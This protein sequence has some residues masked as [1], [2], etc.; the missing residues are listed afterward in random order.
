M[1]EGAQ[2]PRNT[3]RQLDGKDVAILALW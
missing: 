2:T 1:G 3:V